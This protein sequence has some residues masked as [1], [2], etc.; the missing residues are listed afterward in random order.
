[1]IRLEEEI[2][3]LLVNWLDIQERAAEQSAAIILDSEEMR[4][5]RM[6][7]YSMRPGGSND[8]SATQCGTWDWRHLPES[9]IEWANTTQ[10]DETYADRYWKP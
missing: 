10:P 1:M 3:W 9:V 7:L 4:H 6:A 2:K 5:V 8:D